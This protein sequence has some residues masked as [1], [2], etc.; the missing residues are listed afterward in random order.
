MR[1]STGLRVWRAGGQVRDPLGLRRQLESGCLY[2][3]G[4]YHRKG[5]PYLSEI[6]ENDP[7]CSC[8]FEMEG[9]RIICSWINWGQEMLGYVNLE[10]WK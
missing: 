5:Q 10:V 4:A 1:G 7:E 9:D 3:F 8:D 6:N 2:H